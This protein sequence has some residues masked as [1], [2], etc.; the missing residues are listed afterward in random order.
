[1]KLADVK[2]GMTVRGTNM[3][4]L[5]YTVTGIEGRKVCVEHRTGNT[6]MHGGK[7]IPE[8]FTYKVAPRGLS[9]VN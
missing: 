9:A 6:V 1:M 7:Y 4:G 2:I 8:V 5:L 3:F